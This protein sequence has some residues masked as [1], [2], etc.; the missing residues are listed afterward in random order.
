MSPAGVAYGC[1]SVWYM[2]YHGSIKYYYV[3]DLD[4]LRAVL[5]LN[6]DTKI[7]DGD[8]TKENPFVIE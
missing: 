7:S 4:R 6:A 5:N 1:S 2:N 3:S 8:G